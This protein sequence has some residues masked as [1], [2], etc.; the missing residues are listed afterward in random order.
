MTN[1][2]FVD[3]TWTPY[4]PRKWLDCRN[5]SILP[6][7][8]ENSF[9]PVT[10]SQLTGTITTARPFVL[11]DVIADIDTDIGQSIYEVTLHQPGVMDKIEALVKKSTGILPIQVN[12]EYGNGRTVFE[13]VRRIVLGFAERVS[14]ISPIVNTGAGVSRMI[15]AGCQ[16][17]RLGNTTV[18][19][20]VPLISAVMHARMT[21]NGI[22]SN[23]TIIVDETTHV[24][25]PFDAVKLIAAG[26][27]CVYVNTQAR[28]DMEQLN[29]LEMMRRTGSANIRQFINNSTLIE[30]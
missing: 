9:I 18:G 11:R 29:L 22:Q 1:T 28:S 27:N 16:A 21:C 24:L 4:V 3:A 19:N 25:E 12:A 8:E 20:R 23:A 5:V 17:I 6:G 26:A 14:V 13:M 7:F 10:T 30:V 2:K 15:E